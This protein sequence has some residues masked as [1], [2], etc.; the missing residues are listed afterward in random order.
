M[1]TLRHIHR[2]CFFSNE[3]LEA[4][5]TPSGRMGCQSSYG[6]TFVNVD[7][8]LERIALDAS[9][10]VYTKEAYLFLLP[11]SRLKS[12][13]DIHRHSPSRRKIFHD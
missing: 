6:A 3:S 9:L 8:I 10:L 7:L 1:R 5:T 12:D 13:L 4:I 2:R 11:K